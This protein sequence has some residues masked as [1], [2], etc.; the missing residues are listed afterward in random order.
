MEEEYYRIAPI[1]SKAILAAL[2]AAILLGCATPAQTAGLIAGSVVATTVVGGRSPG[3]EIEQVYYLGVFDPQE[4]V[5]PTVYRITV[6]GQ[7]SAISGVK[8]ASGWVPSI[9]IDSLAANVNLDPDAEGSGLSITKD[10]DHLAEIQTGRRMIQFGPE[11]FREA[12][13][14]HRLVIVMGQ[15]PKN[16]FQAIDQSLG[17]ISG[18]QGETANF[19]MRQKLFQSLIQTQKDQERISDI[20]NQINAALKD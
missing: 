10:K 17:A 18:L 14:N 6:H 5:P 15:S 19:A 8:F 11:G 13:R 16:F 2:L 4:Q 1:A 7:A 20:E 9:V 12:P 3:Q